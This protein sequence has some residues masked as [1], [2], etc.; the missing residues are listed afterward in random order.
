[1]GWLTVQFYGKTLCEQLERGW[2]P[3]R[4]KAVLAKVV[5][6]E[7]DSTYLKRQQRGRVA[8]WPVRH[9]PMH[10]GLH[11]SG[12][13]RRYQKCASRSV[14]LQSKRWILSSERIGIFGRRLAWQRLR[15]FESAPAQVILSDADEG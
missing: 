2:W 4:A 1:S 15:H 5:I 10:L 11:Y 12:R 6:T 3:D 14:S 8:S 9:F 13:R 7:M